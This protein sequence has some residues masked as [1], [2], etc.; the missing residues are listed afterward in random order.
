MG[1]VSARTIKIYNGNTVSG[2]PLYTQ[3][4]PSIIEMT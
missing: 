1:T 3:S 4:Y 2:A